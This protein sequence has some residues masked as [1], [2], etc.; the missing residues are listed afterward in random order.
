MFRNCWSWYRRHISSLLSQGAVW[1]K[2]KDWHFRETAC[3]WTTGP[4]YNQ[5]TQLQCWWLHHS[6]C[7]HVHGEFYTTSRLV[8]VNLSPRHCG[9]RNHFCSI[10]ICKCPPSM[11]FMSNW[12]NFFQ[13]TLMKIIKYM[14]KKSP[15]NSEM[16]RC[17]DLKL[18]A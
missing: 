9:C 5:W 16:Y 14:Y 1:R 18:P 12:S 15:K 17:I 10:C 3:R 11:T 7:Q 13:I 4:N 2:S 8:L 6:S